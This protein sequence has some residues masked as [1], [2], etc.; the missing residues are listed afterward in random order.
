MLL[1]F[2]EIYMYQTTILDHKDL[3]WEDPRAVALHTASV[4]LVKF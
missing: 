4:V 1:Q 2:S 3:D